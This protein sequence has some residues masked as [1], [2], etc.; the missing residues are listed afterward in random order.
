MPTRFKHCLIV[1]VSICL[2][3]GLA[4]GLGAAEHY[5]LLSRSSP[6]HMS[7]KLDDVQWEWV[8]NKRELILGT[9]APDYPPFDLTI[10]GQ[11]YEGFTADY[12][13]II[14]SALHLSIKVRRFESR[15]AAIAALA[16]GQ[17]DLLGSANGYEAVERDLR[18]STPYAVD[19]PVLVSRVG[20][21]RPLNQGLANMRLSMVYHYL[22]LKEI[23]ALYPKARLMSYPSFQSAINAVAFNQADVFLGD[24]IST[25]YLINKGYLNNVQMAN[26]GKHERHAA[27]DLRARPSRSLAHVQR[28][29]SGSVLGTTRGSDRQKRHRRHP[30]QQRRGPGV[31]RRLPTRNVERCGNVLNI[32]FYFQRD[33]AI[34]DRFISDDTRRFLT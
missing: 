23:E 28:Q 24:T 19:Q 18:L 12:A 31:R 20:E 1:A 34:K 4:A 22:P 17:I 10:S 33:E 9:S 29:L 3:A 27:S 2:G 21:T 6:A 11:D 26:F 7:V 16:A 30:Q 13:G 5:T 8:R 25:Q 14:S 15:E 32:F